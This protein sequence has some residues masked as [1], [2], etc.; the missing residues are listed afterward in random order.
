MS[1]QYYE[2]WKQQATY[3][4]GFDQTTKEKTQF[5]KDTENFYG[6]SDPRFD[7]KEE[8]IDPKTTIKNQ[9]IM[10]KDS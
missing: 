5:E 8:V 6:S 9:F 2:E 7:V 10:S 4:R 3:S 1:K